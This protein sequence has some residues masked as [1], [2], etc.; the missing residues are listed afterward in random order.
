[1]TIN[2]TTA[3]THYYIQNKRHAELIEQ[4]RKHRRTV[5]RG[6]VE[7]VGAAAPSSKELFPDVPKH[8]MHDL[9][10]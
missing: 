4:W 8:L 3:V 6:G 9:H 2:T 10:H 7:W 1:M 5:I